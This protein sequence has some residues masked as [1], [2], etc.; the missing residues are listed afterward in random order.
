MQTVIMRNWHSNKSGH[1]ALNALRDWTDFLI[2][3][4]LCSYDQILFIILSAITAC[5]QLI[6]RKLSI[7]NSY[8][9]KQLDV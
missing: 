6:A 7:V 1:R 2:V 4:P 9:P 3:K 5:V 8:S